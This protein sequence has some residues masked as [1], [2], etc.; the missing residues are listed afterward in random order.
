[1]NG[2]AC[3]RALFPAV[4]LLLLVPAS[5]A[6][7]APAAFARTAIPSASSVTIDA[8][9]AVR[10]DRQV[11]APTRVTFMGVS[12]TTKVRVVWGDSLP[13]S[14]AW[15]RCLAAAAKRNPARCAVTLDHT[16]TEAGTF[17]I[18]AVSGRTRATKAVRVVAVPKPWT[19]PD[20]WVQ[21]AGW[22][23]IRG[24]T[25]TP[26]Q[27]VQWY[28]DRTGEP[29]DRVR[30]RSDIVDLLAMLA[31]ETGLTFTETN[32]PTAARLTYK[33]MPMMDLGGGQISTA[34]EGR[35]S[36]TLASDDRWYSDMF[37]GMGPVHAEWPGDGG[38]YVFNGPGRSWGAIKGTLAAL[39]LWFLDDPNQLMDNGYITRPALGPGDLDGLHTLYRNN[40]CPEMPD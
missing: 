25:F 2:L 15:G 5:P 36:V 10:L 39:G 21:P 26:C 9:E 29:G 13:N 16:F 8:P 37:A 31:A 22:S 27:N 38:T 32:D 3:L 34:G 19:P 30:M 11:S 28:F 35:G 6:G 4:T 33:W 23:T 20:G 40:P 1:M 14:Q 17:T 12:T 24:A 18:V 7:A